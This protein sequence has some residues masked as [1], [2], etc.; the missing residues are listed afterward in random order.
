MLQ[1]QE[2]LAKPKRTIRRGGVGAP[3]TIGTLACLSDLILQ[4]TTWAT[5]H[6]QHKKVNFHKVMH[7]KEM[8]YARVRLHSHPVRNFS[9]AI[10]KRLRVVP[11]LRDD[12]FYSEAVACLTVLC[13]PDLPVRTPAQDGILW[14]ERRKRGA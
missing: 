6:H 1:G 8:H 14:Y 9:L 12:V 2:G 13:K 11:T 3:G 4:V 10:S 5:L 7:D